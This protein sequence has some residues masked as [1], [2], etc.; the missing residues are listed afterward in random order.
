MERIIVTIERAGEARTRDIEIAA[1]VPVH[2]LASLLAEAL[3]WHYDEAGHAC[4][5]EIEAHPPGRRVH[6]D[7]TLAQCQ[8]WDGARLVL[9]RRSAQS[10]PS[11][12]P[13]L[14]V[15]APSERPHSAPQVSPVAGWTTLGVPEQSR[16][17]SPP[18]DAPQPGGSFAWKPL[19]EDDNS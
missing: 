3:G 9:H 18:A 4:A 17:V 16:A 1:N 12:K 2:Q 8:V 14:P 11:A 10:A 6:P 15:G 5:Y 13:A 7:E 19:D